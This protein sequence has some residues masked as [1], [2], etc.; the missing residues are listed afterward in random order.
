MHFGAVGA[1][2]DRVG[3]AQAQPAVQSGIWEQAERGQRLGRQGGQRAHNQ[4]VVLYLGIQQVHG[5]GRGR[6]IGVDHGQDAHAGIEPPRA[7]GHREA[8]GKRSGVRSGIR[9]AVGQQL[10]GFKHPVYV[11]IDPHGRAVHDVQVRNDRQVY[12]L[13]GIDGNGQRGVVGI[14]TSRHVAEVVVSR[15]A[16]GYVHVGDEE[17]AGLL[18][19]ARPNAARAVRSAVAEAGYR[20]AHRVE[21]GDGG[22]AIGIASREGNGKGAR[23]RVRV[24]RVLQG[25]GGAIAKVPQPR[26]GQVLAGVGEPNGVH[27]VAGY[28]VGREADHG[29]GGVGPQH[30]GIVFHLAAHGTGAGAG[31]VA[32]GIGHHAQT[33]RQVQHRARGQIQGGGGS[34]GGGAQALVYL[35]GGSQ[36]AVIVIIEVH[37]NVVRVHAARGD[38]HGVVHAHRQVGALRAGEILVAGAAIGRRVVDGA[39]PEARDA[40]VGE[41][42]DGGWRAAGCYRHRGII[43]NAGG[44]AGVHAGGVGGA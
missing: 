38:A 37:P 4:L 7:R 2:G 13:A 31:V 26:R 5:A 29:R 25:T 32:H 21:P 3:Q 42:V 15:L 28:V 17:R 36:D 14:A 10:A 20:H 1:S 27:A 18:G 30:H 41:E 24:Q 43:N 34:G 8:G 39:Q 9:H 40:V 6:S 16:I 23:G 33:Q 11:N 22:R 35:L 12:Q 44:A 19:A